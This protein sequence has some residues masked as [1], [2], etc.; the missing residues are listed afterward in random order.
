MEASADQ[1]KSLAFMFQ[2]PNAPKKVFDYLATNITYVADGHKQIILKPKAL[3]VVGQGDCK[4][5]SLFAASVLFNLGYDI[6]LRFTGYTPGQTYPSHVYV[7][8][9]GVIID[10]VY[11][12]YNQEK[13]YT[14]KYDFKILRK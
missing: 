1:A 13:P 6:T 10:A 2:G 5:F 7:I 4:S 14:Y 11:G 8:A 9:N 12:I 3:M